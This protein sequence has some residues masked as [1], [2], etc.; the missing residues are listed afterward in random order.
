M[1]QLIHTIV[2]AARSSIRQ[3]NWYAALSVAVS[4]PD[5][6][7][8]LDTGETGTKSRYVTWFNEWL[9]S[10]Y[11]QKTGPDFMPI[12]VV[13]LS[14]ED[15]YALRCALIHQGTGDIDQQR[16]RKFLTKV[17]FVFPDEPSSGPLHLFRDD[18]TL[19]VQV[20][21][22]VFDICDATESWLAEKE[23]DVGVQARAMGLAQFRPVSSFAFRGENNVGGPAFKDREEAELNGFFFPENWPFFGGES[24]R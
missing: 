18:K 12:K 21:R 5:Q 14:G 15:L 24:A 13:F 1:T 10:K 4:L 20:D 23:S 22:L 3:R 8:F 7:G 17:Q 16:A 2:A 9:A 6:C 19:F 11:E